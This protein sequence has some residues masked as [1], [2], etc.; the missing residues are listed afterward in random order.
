MKNRHC[1]DAVFPFHIEKRGLYN[2]PVPPLG[3]R[4]SGPGPREERWMMRLRAEKK[5]LGKT[6]RV[7]DSHT[8][9][10]PTRVIYDGFPEL[11]G[12]TMM[13]R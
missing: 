10:E 2:D 13:A 9:G 1:C 6:F 7:V 3:G 8:M 4:R 12:S 5:A 11:E